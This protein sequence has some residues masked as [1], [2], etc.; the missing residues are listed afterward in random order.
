[1]PDV[2]MLSFLIIVL[3]IAKFY[4]S[5]NNPKK[6]SILLVV[7]WSTGTKVCKGCIYKNKIWNLDAGNAEA[8]DWCTTSWTVSG[9][10]IDIGQDAVG[11]QLGS[12]IER[13]NHHSPL[14]LCQKCIS[15]AC[16]SWRFITGHKVTRLQNEVGTTKMLIPYIWYVVMY[17]C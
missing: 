2:S 12:Y 16:Y 10:L 11:W 13:W 15:F 9:V 3:H 1:M 6:K 14:P 7:K 8:N 4:G 17:V 5:W